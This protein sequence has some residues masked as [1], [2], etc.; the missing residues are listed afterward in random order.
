MTII[1]GRN[2]VISGWLNFY[3]SVHLSDQG[4]ELY[5]NWND[6]SGLDFEAKMAEIEAVL[7]GQPEAQK[8]LFTV[9]GRAKIQNSATKI[10]T[11]LNSFT[12]FQLPFLDVK[13]NY[14]CD[15]SEKLEEKV[16]F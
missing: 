8:S 15:C 16:F 13:F 10:G 9:R 2:R 7:A 5:N 14:S 1:D 4:S 11:Y 6:N 3:V 12:I